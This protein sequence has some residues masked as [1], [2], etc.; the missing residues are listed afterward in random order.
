[1]KE[2]WFL[3]SVHFSFW[4]SSKHPCI[5]GVWEKEW[6]LCFP[7]FEYENWLHEHAFDRNSE[8]ETKHCAYFI[9]IKKIQ[10]LCFSWMMWT[11]CLW[12]M[13]QEQKGKDLH[14]LLLKVFYASMDIRQAFLG[15]KFTSVDVNKDVWCVCVY[16]LDWMT[17]FSVNCSFT[18]NI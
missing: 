18:V 13:W 12:S 15:K 10:L 8:P 2:H 5:S 14:V 7:H 1:M 17:R 11:S 9:L 16:V 4:Y 6:K 3:T